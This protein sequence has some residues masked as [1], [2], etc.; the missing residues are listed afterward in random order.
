[1]SLPTKKTEVNDDRLD[2]AIGLLHGP[3]KVG[4]STLLAELFPNALFIATEPGHDHLSIYKEDVRSWEKLREVGAELAKGEHEFTHIIVDTA[5][6]LLKFCNDYM[7]Q[8]M[9]VQH[10]S[11]LE[12]GK[13]WTMV[14]DEWRLRLGKLTG[15]GLGVWFVSHSKDVEIKQRVGTV[16][17]AVPNLTGN[18]RE[19]LL[20]L[21]DYIFYANVELTAEGSRHVLRTKASENWEA[22]ARQARGAIALPDPIELD[23]KALRNAFNG[24]N[25]K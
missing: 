4:K 17:K 8:K 19:W 2:K 6:E 15:L 22:G 25:K 23:A 24:T 9:K 1:M 18:P 16:N 3:P 12:W 7:M 14:A 21:A 13:G 10:P 5:D 11:D 20:G